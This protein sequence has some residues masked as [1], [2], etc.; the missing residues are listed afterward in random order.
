MQ[1]HLDLIQCSG[2]AVGSKSRAFIQM[3]SV[4]LVHVLVKGMVIYV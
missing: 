3:V 4:D 1:I 2:G